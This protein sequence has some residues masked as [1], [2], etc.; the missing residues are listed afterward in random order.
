M[1]VLGPVNSYLCLF[2]L[3]RPWRGDDF[4]DGSGHSGTWLFW[5]SRRI[6]IQFRD[7]CGSGHARLRHFRPDAGT[8]GVAGFFLSVLVPHAGMMTSRS[9]PGCPISHNCEICGRFLL[10]ASRSDRHKTAESPVRSRAQTLRVWYL[11][12]RG[13]SSES[14]GRSG[15][16]P[17]LIV[18]KPRNEAA[19][20]MS[21]AQESDRDSDRRAL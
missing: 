14:S 16:L 19:S 5:S 12:G 2:R 3:A 11:L 9:N 15:R 6:E 8:C 18:Q 13:S 1:P 21:F 20:V 4:V 7:S 10:A 17:G